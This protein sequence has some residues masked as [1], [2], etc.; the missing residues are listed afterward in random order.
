MMTTTYIPAQ[1]A[2]KDTLHNDRLWS[3][4]ADNK[5]GAVL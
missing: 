4:D 5:I 1:A 3:L 2:L